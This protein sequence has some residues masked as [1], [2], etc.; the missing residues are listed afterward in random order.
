M[1]RSWKSIA[2]GLL[3]YWVWAHQ[4][5]LKAQLFPKDFPKLYDAGAG[6]SIVGNKE[7][8]GQFKFCED[9]TTVAPG[10]AIFSCDPG[11]L[12]WNTVMGPMIDPNPRGGLW[13]VHYDSS[14][15]RTPYALELSG[16]PTNV[17]FHPLGIEVIPSTVE[18]RVLVINHR[19]DRP[20]IEIFRIHLHESSLSLTFEKTL[21][22]PSITAPNAIAAVSDSAFYLSQDHTFTFRLGWPLNIFLP[23]LETMLALP[24]GR[25]SL[26]QFDTVQG[27][28]KVQ[29]IASRIPFANGVAISEDGSTLAVA[30]TNLAEVQFYARNQTSINFVRS[31]KVPFGADNIAFAGDRLL[32]AGHPYLPAFMALKKGKTSTSPSWV[33]YISPSTETG[34]GGSWI[35]RLAH[36]AKVVDVLKSD[37]SFFTSSSGAF[38]DL[39]TQTMFVVGLYDGNGVAKCRLVP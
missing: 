36:G 23:V 12:K 10:V 4:H 19:R 26:V 38:A 8:N 20:T 9:G 3:S 5:A 11:R 18:P 17:D 7:A 24:L 35:S 32:V 30:A 15:T 13:A 6:C 21:H 22:H 33:S 31:I 29:T 2:V 25:V 1:L 14:S 28:R 37:G 34:T 39:K 27:V 16:F